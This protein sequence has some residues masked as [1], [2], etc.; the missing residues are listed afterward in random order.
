MS[1]ESIYGPIADKAAAKYGIDPGTFRN[2]IRSESSFN[3]N[4]INPQAVNG[5]HASGIAQFL[6]ST[7][8]GQGVDPFNPNSA[9]EGSAK[10]LADL[11]SKFGISGAIAR[12]KGYS[13]PDSSTAKATSAKIIN[14]YP[15]SKDPLGNQ[16]GPDVIQADAVKKRSNGNSKYIWQYSLD[17]LKAAFQESAWGMLFGFLGLL[18]VIFSIYMLTKSNSTNSLGAVQKLAGK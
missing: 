5:E 2:L 18:F 4:A 13:N 11:Q 16:M 3:P 9:L 1:N 17:D 7:A 12:Y 8:S 15:D 14:I 10:Y 6:P